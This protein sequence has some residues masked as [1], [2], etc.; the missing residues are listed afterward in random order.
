MTHTEEGITDV[1]EA[2]AEKAVH[3]LACLADL[4]LF[5]KKKLWCVALLVVPIEA[6]VAFF[7]GSNCLL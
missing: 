5:R 6:P 4:G 2:V 3:A 1:E 7:I